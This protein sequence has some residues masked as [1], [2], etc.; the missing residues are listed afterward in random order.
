MIYSSRRL[1]TIFGA[2][3]DRVTYQQ[4]ADLVGNIDAREAEDLDYKRDYASGD[5]EEKGTEDLAVDIA[6]FANHIGGL[7][8]VGMAEVGEVPSAPQDVALAGWEA[9]IMKAVASRVHPLPRVE[10]RAV[11]NPDTPGSGFML[12]SVHLSSM[13]PHAVSTPSKREAGLRWPRRH[14]TGKIWLSESEIAAAYRKRLM[15]PYDQ[16]A[17]VVQ[18]E[19]NAAKTSAAGVT[20]SQFPLPLLIVSFAPEQPGDLLLDSRTQDDF[21]RSVQQD[22]VMIGGSTV[23]F[24]DHY[25]LHRC[26]VAES[27]VG[28]KR[29]LRVQLYTDGAATFSMNLGCIREVTDQ[30]DIAVLDGEVVAGVMSALQYMARHA[31]DRVGVHGGV[32]ARIAL[33]ADAHLYPEIFATKKQFS[34]WPFSVPNAARHALTLYSARNWIQLTLV[35][36]QSMSF[37]YGEAYLMLDELADDGQPLARASARLINDLFQTYGLAE[38]HQIRQDGSLDPAAWGRNWDTIGKWARASGIPILGES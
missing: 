20:E 32:V 3:L 23:T 16:E 17:R 5:K 9:R 8:V 33:L 6:A 28:T 22:V 27:G 11:A 10:C 26:L 14:G 4:I 15:S 12:I 29:A 7:I 25:L 2:P 31:R 13:A 24:T 34:Q 35:S 36:K 37:G 1:E 21:G 19:K 38:N 30:L 18:L